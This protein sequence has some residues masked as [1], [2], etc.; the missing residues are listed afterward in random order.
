MHILSNFMAKVNGILPIYK[1]LRFKKLQGAP[2]AAVDLCKMHKSK[3]ANGA[4]A[5]GNMLCPSLKIYYQGIITF[6]PQLCL[7]GRRIF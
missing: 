7:Q 5:Q 4:P 2:L 3:A 1:N 6:L